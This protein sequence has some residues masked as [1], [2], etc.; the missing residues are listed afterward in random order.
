MDGWH[1]GP[2]AGVR[3]G[4]LISELVLA[5]YAFGCS[6]Y[7]SELLQRRGPDASR[8]SRDGG[9]KQGD[10]MARVDGGL[11]DASSDAGEPK[12][13]AS[14][15]TTP[16]DA[17]SCAFGECWWSQKAGDCK[18][19][20]AP[21]PEDRPNLLDN[22]SDKDVGEIYLG[23]SRLWLGTT[24]RD[25]KATDTAWQGFGLDLDGVCT[26]S[27]TCPSVKNAVSCHSSASQIPFDGELCRD[28]TF[29][30]LQPVVARVP[31]I[32]QKFGL[33]EDVFNCALWRG[34]YNVIVRVSG[35]N[36]RADDSQ[37][38]VDFYQS[39]GLEQAQ[40]WKCP[41]D[42]Y[43]DTYPLWRASAT[44]RIDESTLT[45]AITEPG[46]LPDST[47]AD[48]HA[49]VKSGYLVAA[50]PDG[51]TL[52]LAGNGMP[53]R[54]FPLTAHRGLWIG[55]L[56][57]AQDSTW[58]MRDGLDTGRTRKEELIKSFREIGLCEG[59][60][61]DSFYQS[62]TTYV[63]ENADLLADGSVSPDTPC[64]AMSFGLGFEASQV[65]PG[66]PARIE[67]LIECCP[68]GKSIQDCMAMCGDGKLNGDEQCDTKIAAGKTGA[69]PTSCPAINA[70]TP[71]VVVGSACTA[72][73]EPMPIT[74][75]KAGDGCCPPGGDMTL[76]SDCPKVCGN[77]VLE[78]GE[79]CDPIASC[80]S[81]SSTNACLMAVALGS[82]QLCTAA[83]DLVQVTSCVNGDGCCPAGC[84]RFGST[85]DSDCPMGCND[86]T[87]DTSMGET[88][89]PRST[90]PASCDDS[91]PCTTD[92]M[93]GSASNC[94]VVCTHTPITQ[95][96]NGD[97]CCPSNNGANATNDNDCAAVCGNHIVEGSE[98]CDDGNQIAGDGC[99]DCKNETPEQICRVK[100]GAS[101]ACALCSCAN[102]TQAALDCYGASSA[103][104]VTRC[105]GLVDCGVANK[106]TG[107]ACYCGAGV[108]DLTCLFGGPA[109]PCIPQVEAAAGSTNPFTIQ[110]LSTDLTSPLGRADALG[111][112]GFMKCKTEC[113]L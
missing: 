84:N 51:A 26:N 73:C 45:G 105:K 98:Q 61:L 2:S 5:I 55:N 39:D 86:G 54:G 104:E 64:D 50:I 57:K 66:A 30:S 9:R 49:Y 112:C 7:K 72:H 108:S 18:S 107:N 91:D 29:A 93:T 90:C 14:D 63:D 83:C 13:A 101:D 22:V 58:H 42:N 80:P 59:L 78:A 8:V 37:V 103:D 95:P 16:F 19:A 1:Q 3:A 35:Y 62:V 28:N 69:C 25:G 48:P 32:G 75:F 89:D 38:R 40:G 65:T 87:V 11:N 74:A 110:T 99:F 97:G 44:W 106:C 79:T 10:G 24:D 27:S 77:G 43:R 56:Y 21:G 23:W 52:R 46:H 6:P 111:S 15:A 71:Q 102:C 85:F 36:G 109:G 76:D 41:V 88:C 33:S 12:D 67:P 94:N 17:A 4:A 92:V 34:D 96:K 100:I 82:A 68:A 60:G 47:I 31:E 53:Y 81:C 113:G 70:C 20:G